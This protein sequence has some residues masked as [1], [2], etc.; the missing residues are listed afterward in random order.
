MNGTLHGLGIGPGDPELITLKALRLLRAAAVVAYPAPEN[1]DSL[2]RE[3]VAGHLPGGQIEVAIRMPMRVERFPA[4][5]VYDRAAA[6]LG[7]HLEAGRDVAVLCE[8]D[9]FLYGSFMY[10][11][12]R[13]AERFP[14]RVVPGV[15]SL[16]ACAAVLGAPLAAR[17]DVLSVL[18]APLDA[19]VLRERLAAADAAAVVKLGRHF[20]KVRTVLDEL[21]LAGNARYVERAT[22]DSQR[23][24]PLS[25]VE[26][27]SVPYF[28]MILVHKRG[29]AW[30]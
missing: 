8:G 21:G 2:A 6:E 28:S 10:L 7:R 17:N 1:G 11:F 9:P 27:G 24:L 20:A 25:E 15:S 18:P 26:P 16:T 4:Q 19:G 29:E 23:V 14:V 12:G 5:E 22:M 13:M 3:I 30:S